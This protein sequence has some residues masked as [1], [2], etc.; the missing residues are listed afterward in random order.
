[1]PHNVE[2]GTPEA[3]Y[4][5]IGTGTE[6]AAEMVTVAY[7]WEMAARTAEANGR[8]DWARALRTGRM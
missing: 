7:D 8:A 4:A 2:I 3:R 6:I 5:I 1:M